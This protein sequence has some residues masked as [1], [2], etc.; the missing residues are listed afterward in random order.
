MFI[1]CFAL[2]GIT[3]PSSV[4]SIER[5]AFDCCGALKD[6][7]FL[8][9][10]EQWSKIRIG[11]DNT[12]LTSATIHYIDTSATA[13]DAVI[14]DDSVAKPDDLLDA[15]DPESMEPEWPADAEEDVP[16]H[17]DVLLDL[18]EESAASDALLTEADTEPEAL[19]FDAVSAL[20]AVP[21]QPGADAVPEALVDA[22]NAIVVSS[23]VTEDGG[24]SHARFTGLTAGED[25][26]VI[27]SCSAD[28]PLDG[29]NLLYI[30][31]TAV[32]ADGTL[33]VPFRT[34]SVGDAA[35]VVACRRGNDSHGGGTSGGGTSGGGTSGGGTSSDGA[36]GLLAILAGG[37]AVIVT[38]IIA[39]LPAKISGRVE[40]TDH[41][42][43]ANA[44]VQLLQNNTVVARTTTD[45]NGSF[46]LSAKRSN[47]VLRITYPVTTVDE[48][49]QLIIRMVT[50]DVP[51][52]APAKGLTLTF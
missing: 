52:K 27:V 42:V 1:D 45:A 21:E 24:V 28:A 40:R 11:R 44:D 39:I 51:V 16:K 15:Y 12:D 6:V 29:A 19:G 37:V 34:H 2:E 14:L 10:K 43:L 47:Y 18:T 25:Y 41:T 8:G 9:T 13:V 33:D 46:T 23:G 3:I 30:T 38:G 48:A 26:A 22:S 49:G 36:G 50:Q 17:N 31:Q 35:Y 32:G 5:Q 7:C 20:P 4:T